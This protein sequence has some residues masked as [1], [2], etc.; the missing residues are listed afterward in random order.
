MLRDHEI[1]PFRIFVP[2]FD[3]P[4]RA[5]SSGVGADSGL[6]TAVPRYCII[7]ATPLT[8]PG[9]IVLYGKKRG[10]FSVPGHTCT[11]VA[12]IK[13]VLASERDPFFGR[14]QSSKS[15]THS[16]SSIDFSPDL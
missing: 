1:D 2:R 11:L 16:T 10:W 15:I 9:T 4:G 12:S 8:V 5:Y 3:L 13:L 14:T 6:E 7:G